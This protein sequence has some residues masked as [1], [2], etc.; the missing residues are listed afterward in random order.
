LASISSLGKK[1]L[2]QETISTSELDRAV[3]RALRRFLDG[4]NWPKGETRETVE[5]MWEDIARDVTS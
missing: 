3:I 1:E 4:A 5:M 2:R